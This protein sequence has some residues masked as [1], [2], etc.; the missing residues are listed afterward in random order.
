[1]QASVCRTDSQLIELGSFALGS[2]NDKEDRASLGGT[3][4]PAMECSVI[5]HQITRLEREFAHRAIF[6][7]VACIHFAI[8]H[9]GKIDAVGAVHP[10]TFFSWDHSWGAH[11]D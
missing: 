2:Q 1:M 5:H 9:D 6:A 11:V 3:V 10:I 4:V 7:R 8:H